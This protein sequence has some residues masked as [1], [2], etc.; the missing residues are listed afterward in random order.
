MDS[1][2]VDREYFQPANSGAALA[3]VFEDFARL[4]TRLMTSNV[5]LLVH[6]LWY[7][8]E[9]D[10]RMPLYEMLYGRVAAPGISTGMLTEISR[11][12]ERCATYP[13]TNDGDYVI[14]LASAPT[15]SD[16]YPA[17]FNVEPSDLVGIVIST[18]FSSGPAEISRRDNGVKR[19][20][21][22]LTV[23]KSVI[24]SFRNHIAEQSCS[25]DCFDRY[26]QRAFPALKL[27]PDLDPENLN[28]DLNQLAPKVV[29]HLSFLN[30]RYIELGIQEAWDF[31]RMK[32]AAAASG[33]DFSDESSNTKK[34]KK[35]MHAREVDI[36]LNGEKKTLSC[37][38]HTKVQPTRGRIHF[39][40]DGM[41][42]TPHVYV[43]IMHEHLPT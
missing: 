42:D 31:P 5:A 10:A 15:Q 6:E 4:T 13:D 29:A 30:D 18:N 23:E 33:L 36:V 20:V 22:I 12:F 21:F 3:E 28:V 8:M 2:F 1:I 24:E 9:V 41:P 27:N 38:L 40:V 25:K 37:T 39:C 34:D 11:I 19:R 16:A 17:A 32:A 7:E 43:G 35:C 14:D 26:A